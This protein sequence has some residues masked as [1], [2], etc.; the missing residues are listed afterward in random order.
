MRYIEA[1]KDGFGLINRNWQ[2]VLIQVGMVF[3]SILGFFIVVGIPLAIAFIIFG[4]DLTGIADLRDIFGMLRGPSDI[5]SRY[6]SFILI[7]IASILLYVLAVTVLGMYLFGGSV[8][9][10]GMSIKEKTLKFSMRRFTGEAKRLFLRLLAFTSVIGL[11]FIFAAFCLGLLGGGIAAIVSYAR[12]QDSTLALFF[13]TFFSLI[14]IILSLSFILGSLSVTLYGI[15]ALYFKGSGAFRSIK[16]AVRFLIKYPDGFWLYAVLF[17]CYLLAS[18]L[19]G[20]LNYPFTLIPFLGT[21]LSFPY[22][23]FSYVVQTYL[24][25]VIIAVIQSYYYSKEFPSEPAET[26]AES[27]V[28]GPDAG[29]E[30]TTLDI[31]ADGN[32]Q[33]TGEKIQDI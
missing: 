3:A 4:V 18:F 21:I 16:D 7:I 8:G 6:L 2:L 24:G 9:I 31:E 33:D 22:Q 10:I 32:A 1:I 5:L 28:P 29:E 27:P 15:A 19:L 20:L 17:V 30:N 12:S 13:V 11:I 23:F 14:V 26:A 25:L